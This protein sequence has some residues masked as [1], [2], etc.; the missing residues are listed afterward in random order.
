PEPL[1][2]PITRSRIDIKNVQGRVLKEYDGI[3]Y[4]KI[5][6]F[7]PTTN[8]E[9]GRMFRQLSRQVKS[10]KLR[11]LV[12]DLRRNSGGLLRQGIKIAD[13]FLRSGAIVTV[14]SRGEEDEVHEATSHGTWDVPMV[15]LVDDGSASASEIVAS[16]LQD[17]GR[18][19]VI[20]DRT[21]GKASVQT[22]FSP[23]LRDDYYIKLTVARYFSP[24]GRTLQVVGVKPD[25]E[26]TPELDGD[27]PLGFR[28]EN[29]SHHLV[30]LDTN[31]RSANQAW[32][33]TL[34]PCA[35]KT[36]RAREIFKTDPN[37]AVRFDYPVMRAA[38]LIQ[39]MLK[40]GQVSARSAP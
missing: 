3:G 27:M 35:E 9:M 2:I 33:D 4:A 25:V 37:P 22:L 29:L 18:A 32:A 24:S 7:V 16:A 31:Y 11:G 6:G 15:L 30:A 12:L 17:G 5:T 21:F 38:D 36:G 8:L 39:C 34:V 1:E 13:R 28:E 23:M 26:V 20:G 14:K 40:S 19:L 10:G